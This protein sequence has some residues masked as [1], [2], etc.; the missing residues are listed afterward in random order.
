M[1]C[2][3]C[4]MQSKSESSQK[5]EEYIKK[6]HPYLQT[7]KTNDSVTFGKNGRY[8]LCIYS[9]GNRRSVAQKNLN[10]C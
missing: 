6:L 2:I 9:K 4:G 5:E 1:E 7:K 10:L 3:E 8:D